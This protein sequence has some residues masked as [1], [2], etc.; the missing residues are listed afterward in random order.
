MHRIVYFDTLLFFFWSRCSSSVLCVLAPA[1]VVQCLHL[2]QNQ[3]RHIDPNSHSDSD[4]HSDNGSGTA[5]KQSW[6]AN[7]PRFDC[8]AC[9]GEATSQRAVP[10][11]KTWPTPALLV[12][13]VPPACSFHLPRFG[14]FSGFCGKWETK[15]QQRPARFLISL[16]GR[17]LACSSF[18]Y[19]NNHL[20]THCTTQGSLLDLLRG[21]LLRFWVS[22]HN[23]P[24]HCHLR[25]LWCAGTATALPAFSVPQRSASIATWKML[26][27]VPDSASS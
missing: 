7:A 13:H 9:L 4:H 19:E 22:F 15:R 6:R 10:G 18:H 8:S 20:T 14:R 21:G 5:R 11:W 16:N 24:D 25:K 27:R 1:G 3:A 2:S 26:S 12:L 17:W 23:G